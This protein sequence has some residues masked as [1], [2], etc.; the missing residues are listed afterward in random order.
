VS[1]VAAINWARTRAQRIEVQ[2]L[3]PD[4]DLPIN[5]RALGLEGP[6]DTT[7]YSDIDYAMSF[8]NQHPTMIRLFGDRR[9][10]RYRGGFGF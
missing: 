3:R 6:G 9:Y 5:R 2:I 10:R 4:G 1:A 7:D 8:T